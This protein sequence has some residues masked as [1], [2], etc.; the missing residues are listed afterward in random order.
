MRT[1]G[2]TAA[3]VVVFFMALLPSRIRH[4]EP[5]GSRRATPLSLFN[6]PRDIPD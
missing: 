4:P 5:T 3:D 6:I 1:D 2:I